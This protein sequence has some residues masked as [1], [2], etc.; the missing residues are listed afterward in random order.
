MVVRVF[1]TVWC[2][3]C[4]MAKDFLK[5]HNVKF[6]DINV[7]EHPERAEEMIRISGQTGVP[8]I[9]ANGKIIIGYNREAIKQALKIK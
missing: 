6:E 1:S 4:K 2:P 9:D 8:V 3:Y 5:D 7:Q